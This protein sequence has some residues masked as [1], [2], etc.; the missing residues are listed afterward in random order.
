[1]AG[2]TK[3]YT[4]TDMEE[5]R[6]I[7]GGYRIEKEEFLEIDGR[8]VLSL[9]GY[10]VVDSSCCGVGGCRFAYVPGYVVRERFRQNE[11][12]QWISEVEPVTDPGVRARIADRL[13]KS[14]LAQQVNFDG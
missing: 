13:K 2:L 14:E 8:R 5:V 11:T 6:S 9:V 1:M 10:G 4:H 12:G 7:S 3:E